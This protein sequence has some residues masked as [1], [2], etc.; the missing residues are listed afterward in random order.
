[1]ADVLN[2]PG[3]SR[4]RLE[5]GTTTSYSHSSHKSGGRRKCSDNKVSEAPPKPEPVAEP[6]STDIVIPQ[7][8]S[9]LIKPN[10][11]VGHATW[12]LQSFL[13]RV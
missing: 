4:L 7:Q 12:L 5:R 13:L 9:V 11:A 1:M 10:P 3:E 6:Y 2:S 8:L